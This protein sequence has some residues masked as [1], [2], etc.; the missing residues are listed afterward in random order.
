MSNH[1]AHTDDTAAA[2]GL[3]P[4]PLNPQFAEVVE[5]ALA[6][7]EARKVQIL[8]EA[9]AGTGVQPWERDWPLGDFDLHE[10]LAGEWDADP[11]LLAQLITIANWALRSPQ[12]RQALL[13]DGQATN[14]GQY[15]LDTV[16]EFRDALV[17]RQR[18]LLDRRANDDQWM[19]DWPL[20]QFDL[21]EH[22]VT[23]TSF[24]PDWFTTGELIEMAEW[25]LNAPEAGELSWHGDIQSPRHTDELKVQ[26][27]FRDALL[28]RR[29]RLLLQQGQRLLPAGSAAWRQLEQRFSSAC[30]GSAA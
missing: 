15:T 16:R 5:Q 21:F 17:F 13:Q 12:G 11:A 29:Q 3:Q 23:D 14:P 6:E 26:G 24:R 19:R 20:G 28:V 9:A 4:T 27:I 22:M 1:D 7:R 18:D 8:A 2:T 10:H 25:A 30:S